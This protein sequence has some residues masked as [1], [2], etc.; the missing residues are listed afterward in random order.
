MPSVVSLSEANCPFSALL[1]SSA[2]RSSISRAV[3][4]PLYCSDDG[5]RKLH[6]DGRDAEDRTAAEEPQDNGGQARLAHVSAC[7]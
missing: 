5:V 1:S 3:R 7:F 6:D 2:R 4:L